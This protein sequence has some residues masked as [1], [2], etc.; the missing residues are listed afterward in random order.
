MKKLL[1]SLV[2]ATLSVSAI[3]QA[4]A[5]T[6]PATGTTEPKPKP[7]SVTDKKFVKDASEAILVEQ[8]YLALMTDQKLEML[9]E[10][11]KR[12]VKKME[13]ELKRIWTALATLATMKNTEVAQEISK[14]DLTKI[15][16][17]TKEKPDKFEKE[18]FKDLGKETK[19][20]VK[21]F[22]SF[23]TLQDPDVKKFAEDWATVTKGHDLA[24]ETGEKSSAKKK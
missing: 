19:K 6:A 15:E 4:P 2:G 1:L 22:E 9:G 3:A 13:G 12:D 16:K 17:L 11:T 18:F 20:T 5:T 21:L 10:T 7:L 24:A 14:N 8:K 23:K